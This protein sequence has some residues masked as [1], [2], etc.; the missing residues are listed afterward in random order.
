MGFLSGGGDR[1]RTDVREG[2][3]K[4]RYERSLCML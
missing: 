3:T 1:N 4:K 2:Q